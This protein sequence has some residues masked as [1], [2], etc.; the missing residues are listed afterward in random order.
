M[1]IYTMWNLKSQRASDFSYE[2]SKLCL[3]T[4]TASQK[5]VTNL[6]INAFNRS[7][8]VWMKL[9]K[10]YRQHNSH[11]HNYGNEKRKTLESNLDGV[12]CFW[13]LH[14]HLRVSMERYCNKVW[15]WKANKKNFLVNIAHTIL[16]LSPSFYVSKL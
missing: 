1:T 10:Q 7:L 5:C 12:V 6:S 4:G 16:C 3:V 8:L 2:H 15:K 14:L 9:I 13:H 11:T